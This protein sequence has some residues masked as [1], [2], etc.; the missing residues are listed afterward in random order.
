MKVVNFEKNNMTPLTIKEHER[1]LKETNICKKSFK[2]NTIM[3]ELEIIASIGKYRGVAYSIRNLKYTKEIP[4][5]FH[6]ES[7]YYD[8]FTIKELAK[9][10][11]GELNCLGENTENTFLIPL[12]KEFKRISK[13]GEEITKTKSYKLQLIDIAKFMTSYYKSC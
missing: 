2:V 1:Y 12:K 4:V 6:N 11:E 10:F 9:E 5:V 13:N 7:K 3:T 8:H